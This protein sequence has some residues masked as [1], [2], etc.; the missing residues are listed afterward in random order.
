MKIVHKKS[1]NLFALP[2]TG[3]SIRSVEIRWAQNRCRRTTQGVMRVAFYFT[4][5]ALIK[6]VTNAQW[7]HQGA[8]MNQATLTTTLEP[9]AKSD[10]DDLENRV[11]ARLSG[12]IRDLRLL[13]HDCG[14]ILRGFARTYHAKQLAQHVVMTETQLPILANEIEVY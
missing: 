3:G 2:I 4:F 1:K 7:N 5:I 12:R 10:L 13:S 11:Q 9:D 8:T 6:L 14:I